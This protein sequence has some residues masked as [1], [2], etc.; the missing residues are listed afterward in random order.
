MKIEPH[1]NG[2]I[3]RTHPGI[4]KTLPWKEVAR[5][6]AAYDELVEALIHM[7]STCESPDFDNRP[8]NAAM[9]QAR[10]TLAKVQG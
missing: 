6:L 5:Q 3:L 2:L 8:S 1:T 4:A 10:A 7:V 9:N